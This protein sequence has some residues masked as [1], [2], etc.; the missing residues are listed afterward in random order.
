MQTMFTGTGNAYADKVTVLQM[1]DWGS[2]G[3][4]DRFKNQPEVAAAVQFSIGYCYS[5]IGHWDTAAVCLEDSLKLRVEALGYVNP[6]TLDTA[7]ELVFVLLSLD[8]SG[9]ARDLCTKIIE[10]ARVGVNQAATNQTPKARFRQFELHACRQ[11]TQ[12]YLEAGKPSLAR[13]L[14]EELV[15]AAENGELL[16]EE[17]GYAWSQLGSVA[18]DEGHPRDALKAFE[19]AAKFYNAASIVQHAWN[20]GMRGAAHLALGEYERAENLMTNS[21]PV[22]EHRFGDDHFRVQR[23]YRDLIA[24]YLKTGRENEAD[25]IKIKQKNRR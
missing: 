1:L 23:A 18:L 15:A 16:A 4:K 25:E 21:L 5:K 24:L 17:N 8:R 19:N 22:L 12:I 14:A 6:D 7:S 13:P 11:L 3:A 10:S 9:E 2:A 20:D